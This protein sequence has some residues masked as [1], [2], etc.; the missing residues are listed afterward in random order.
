M[1]R[2][3]EKAGQAVLRACDPAP[4]H[5]LA[6]SP[7]R[8][9]LFVVSVS[10]AVLCLFADSGHAQNCFNLARNVDVAGMDLRR[11]RDASDVESAKHHLRS[12]TEGLEEAWAAAN[13]CNC[14]EAASEFEEALAYAR[15]ARDANSE[16]DVA[17]NLNRTL[18][19]F[20][21]GL[22]TLRGCRR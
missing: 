20:N 17:A 1:R 4:C 3:V 7:A 15:R 6:V 8:R 11:A 18:R 13:D 5:E 21:A 16:V 12:A 14:T 22:E 2:N 19:Y 9:R 10:A